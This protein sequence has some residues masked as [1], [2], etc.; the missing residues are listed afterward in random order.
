MIAMQVTVALQPL[1]PCNEKYSNKFDELIKIKLSSQGTFVGRDQSEKTQSHKETKSKSQSQRS[2]K[3]V[4]ESRGDRKTIKLIYKKGHRDVKI[5]D[6]VAVS[7][8]IKQHQVTGRVPRSIDLTDYF[9]AT[10]T[11]F[12]DYIEKGE[13]KAQISFYALAELLKLTKTFIMEDLQ[14]R[15][16]EAQISF[17]ALAELLKLT[18]TFIM[19]DLQK[20]L[21][22]ILI[23]TAE[24]ST[25]HLI[26][27]VLVAG[28]SNITKETENAL[29]YLASWSFV[30]MAMLPDF[31]R[32]PYHQFVMLLASCELRVSH[33]L[34]VA[35]A[36]LLW[37]VGQPHP[38]VYAP[39]VF[40]VIRSAFLSKVD[41]QLIIE[42]I[43]T[44]QM[45][46]SVARF[47]RISM[48]SRHNARVCL[49]GTH[50]SRHLC[51]CGIPVPEN[52]PKEISLSLSRPREGI[53][54]NDKNIEDSK[55]GGSKRS[56][57]SKSRKQRSKR[58]D[59][60]KS[61]RSNNTDKSTR[62]MNL[63]DKTSSRRSS[64]HKRRNSTKSLTSDSAKNTST[65]SHSRKKHGNKK[66]NTNRR[67]AKYNGRRKSANDRRRRR[68]QNGNGDKI[69]RRKSRSLN[70]SQSDS[71]H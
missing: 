24:S 34:V 55:R 1:H 68:S 2:F 48:E 67:G 60:M 27:A 18:K 13:V 69:P 23:L 22:E 54:W 15:L 19:E 43:A 20:R 4:S 51:R 9:N 11:V 5:V 64:K 29:H 42:R 38:A 45:P 40:A 57:K 16:E 47:A 21:E 36:A 71:R 53:K 8:L 44:L 66:N 37:L 25:N 62:S 52:R 49:E 10:I 63:S 61:R 46:E 39:G 30:E 58:R 50:I 35:D 12:A 3:D 65:R 17:Y 31:Q 28:T 6:F 14:K 41:R 7:Q 32:I 56:R 70:R 26:Q 33:E 59:S